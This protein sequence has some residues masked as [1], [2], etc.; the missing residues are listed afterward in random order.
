MTSALVGICGYLL[1]HSGDEWYTLFTTN[2]DTRR[3][4][5]DNLFM[6]KGGPVSFGSVKQ[7][8]TAQSK[9]EAKLISY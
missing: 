9:V 3:S 4:T 1:D 2:L 7:T 6:M 5:T 8:L